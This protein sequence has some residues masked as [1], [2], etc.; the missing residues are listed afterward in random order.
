MD[1][2]REAS[3]NLWCSSLG[4]CRYAAPI[5]VDVEYTRG[6]EIVRR[7]GVSTS[8]VE[9]LSSHF[10]PALFLRRHPTYSGLTGCFVDSLWML[11]GCRVDFS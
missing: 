3:Q 9:P 6:R 8:L 11:S 7:V 10:W 5:T 4:L 1:S 2:D